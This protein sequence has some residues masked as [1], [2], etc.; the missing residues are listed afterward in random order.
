M[1]AMRALGSMSRNWP[2]VVPVLLW[3]NAGS[4]PSI[5]TIV[6]VRIRRLMAAPA[7]T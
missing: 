6:Q 5:I 4:A 7:L 1:P 2:I 3:P